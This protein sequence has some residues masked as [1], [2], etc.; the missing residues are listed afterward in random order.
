MFFRRRAGSPSRPRRRPRRPVWPSRCGHRRPRR[1]RAGWSPAARAPSVGCRLGQRTWPGPDE[2]VV[3]EVDQAAEPA[4]ARGHADEDEQRP[5]RRRRAACRSGCPATVTASSAWSPCSSRTSVSDHD[6]HVRDPRDLVDEV[7]GHVLAQVGFA[8]DERDLRWRARTGRPP[9][10]R[11]SCRRRRWPPGPRRT[12]APPPATP[13]SRCSSSRSSPARGTSSLR[14]LTPVARTT[15]G[16][17]QAG[18][19]AEAHPVVAVVLL[20]GGGLGRDG[21]P[22]A[23]LLRLEQRPLRELGAGDARREAEVVLDPRRGPGLAP[24]GGGVEDD[25]PACPSE[26]PYTAADRPAGPDPTTSRSQLACGALGAGSPIAA[27]SSALLGL[28]S[29]RPCTITTGV[30]CGVTPNWA[31]HGLGGRVGLQ[32]QPAVREPVPGREVAD[33]PGVRGVPRADDPQA[34][35]EPDQDRAA[36]QVGAQDQVAERRDRGPPAP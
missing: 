10:A 9:P 32:V 8:D 33:P 7:A 17:G 12:A 11:P 14:Y 19:V 27:A 22:G 1:C 6:M 36:Q 5:G 25:R 34:D 26:A 31:E 28:R 35:A 2:S 29:S 15:R 21:E 18:P 30:S 20:D 24:G 3:I 16:A 4:R 13:R 23:E